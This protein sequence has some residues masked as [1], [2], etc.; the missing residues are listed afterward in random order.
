MQT[1]VKP[2]TTQTLAEG[3]ALIR[4]GELVGMPTETVYGLGGNALD[5][6]AA[7]RYHIEGGLPNTQII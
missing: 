6:R 2:V 1:Y 4:A 5:A 7:T 3:G